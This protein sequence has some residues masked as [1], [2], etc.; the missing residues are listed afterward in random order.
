MNKVQFWI[1]F[2]MNKW[3][4]LVR[5]N[6]ILFWWYYKRIPEFYRQWTLL[7]SISVF[8]GGYKQIERE[9]KAEAKRADEYFNKVVEYE[10]QNVSL[11]EQWTKN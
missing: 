11:Y 10:R 2:E 4:P 9:W 7:K 8:V 6:R 3:P 1:R 5:I